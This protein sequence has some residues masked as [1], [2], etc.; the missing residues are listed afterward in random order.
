[1]HDC[2]N[3]FQVTSGNFNTFTNNV[4]YNTSKALYLLSDSNYTTVTGNTFYNCTKG[5]ISED[6]KL[7]SLR[8]EELKT[9]KRFEG[10]KEEIFTQVKR[11]DNEFG[12]KDIPIRLLNE[13]K[14]AV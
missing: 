4:V 9:E 12:I 3:A 14:K 2:T 11:L 5:I 7:R 10:L 8:N 1:M 6:D 13:L